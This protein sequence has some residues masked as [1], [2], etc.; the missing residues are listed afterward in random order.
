MLSSRA[1]GKGGTS[2][3]R[4]HKG[5]KSGKAC[6]H[7]MRRSK[8][9]R[10]RQNGYIWSRELGSCGNVDI[11]KRMRAEEGAV[12]G[13]LECAAVGRRIGRGCSEL[14]QAG[15]MLE[16]R[17]RRMAPRQEAPHV[18]PWLTELPNTYGR[19]GAASGVSQ[20]DG[21]W[22]TH[23]RRAARGLLPDSPLPPLPPPACL[24]PIY[25][26]AGGLPQ[27]CVLVR[28]GQDVGTVARAAGRTVGSSAHAG[29]STAALALL[30]TV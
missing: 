19:R 23:E 12:G 18:Q 21:T 15:A 26:V 11:Q 17:Q 24:R 6:V 27:S 3:G 16:W 8:P 20:R 10:R 7:S 2:T 25:A 4:W 28:G 13:M 14:E 1:V 30:R 29:G 5:G 9:T 22:H